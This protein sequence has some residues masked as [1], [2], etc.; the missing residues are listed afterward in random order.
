MPDYV[1]EDLDSC[2]IKVKCERHHAKELSDF[3]TFKV[4]GHKFMPSY[5]A[6]KWDGQIKLYNMYSQKIYAG[7]ES[8][9]EKFCQDR[10]YTCEKPERKRK[11]WSKDHLE[12]L[13]SGLDIQLGGKPVKPHDH[14][15][16]AILHGMNTERCLLLS[17]TGSGKSLIIYTLMRHFMNLTPEDKKVLVIV[18]TVGLVSQMFHDFIEYGGEGWNARTHCHMLYSGKEKATR[19][20]VVIST[21]QS[22]ANMPE[23]FFQ[24]FGTVFGDE[25]H[26]FKSKSLKQ[27]MSRLTTCPYRIAT[28]GTLDGLLT[29]K[30]VI[31][32][33][34]GPT[35]KV[36]T[37]K[38][39]M[40]RKLLSN[41]TIDCLMLSYNGTDRQ[42]MR[43]TRY[44]DEIEWIVTDER[45]NKFI[46][47]L[48][49]RTKGNT[50]VLFQF[51]E[52]HGKVLHEMLKDSKKPVHF[53]YGGTDVEQR[54][55][56]RKLV[57]E[58]D[59]SIIIASYGTFSTGV[60]IKRLNNIVFASPSKSRVRVLQSIGRQLRKSVH[61]ST[62]RLYDIV[63]DLS[64]KKYE[65]HTLRH[66]YERKKIYD[67]EG[68]DYKIVKIPLTG[69]R[70]EQ[71]PLQGS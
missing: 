13:L 10:G 57:E 68:F 62:A 58:T 19:S 67:A 42:F 20:R 69:E 8:Y 43:R 71:N 1:I 9:I 39:L 53:I 33:L 64:W 34:F 40:E 24:Q 52:K 4:P 55:A 30:L 38:K 32:G 56:V 50:L 3:F 5:R 36:V 26:L 48:A 25:A 45:R 35:K 6:K 23:E 16:E 51:V 47:D 61:K 37:T 7:L 70:N 21:W 12:S 17:P 29:H 31:E 15:K 59:D 27:I 18:P 28:T 46:C 22:L 14:Q 49:E 2:N 11:K 60:N 65:N 66:F 63:D 44:A 41:L 54:E